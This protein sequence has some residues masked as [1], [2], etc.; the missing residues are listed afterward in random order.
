MP[1]FLLLVAVCAG[2]ATLGAN[3][4]DSSMSSAVGYLATSA[5]SGVGVVLRFRSALRETTPRG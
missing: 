2:A 5:V 4:L 1:S 3:N